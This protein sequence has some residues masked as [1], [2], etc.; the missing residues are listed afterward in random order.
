MPNFDRE[1]ETGTKRDVITP[2]IYVPDY[3]AM[4]DCRVCGHAWDAY[5]HLYRANYPDWSAPEGK[6]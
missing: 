3:Q 6:P 2:H 5:W 1:H 4:G